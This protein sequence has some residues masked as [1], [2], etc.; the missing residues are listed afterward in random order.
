MASTWSARFRLNYQAPGDNLN[1]WGNVLN[2]GV[3]QLIEDAIAGRVAFSLSGTKT[4]T[5]VNGAT[6]E[7]RKA[8][9]DVTGGS[10]GTI[11]IP[12]LEKIY[13]VRNGA[14]GN[15]IISCGGGGATSTIIPTEIICV[16]C[17]GVNVRRVG[18]TDFG[19]QKI[20]NIAAPTN[21]GDAVNKAY[22]DG[23]AFGAV[24]LPGQSGADGKYLKSNGTTAGWADVPTP[25]PVTFADA[26]EM[27]AATVADKVVS[28]SVAGDAP[29]FRSLT[30]ASTLTWSAASKGPNVYVTLTGNTAIG[31]PTNLK[32]AWTYV[33]DVYQDG[34]G[35]RSITSWDTIWDFGALGTQAPASTA[36]K[37][38]KYVAQYC[39][40]RNKLEVVGVWRQG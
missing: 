40:A 13:L 16:V 18:S 23:L 4:L 28:P 17:D 5:T 32:D 25:T 7:A 20:T 1:L 31:A 6:D 19:G 38:T 2:A 26:G 15:V 14:V 10:G 22:A 30:W 35:G 27:I 24:D 36:G 8:F 37:K 11:T 21:S 12:A 9:I 39:A 29:A 34:T 33:L 3:F